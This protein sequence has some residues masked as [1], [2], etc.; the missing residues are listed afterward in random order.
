MQVREND[1]SLIGFVNRED[2]RIFEQLTSVTGVGAK[3]A[4]SIQSTLSASE[5]VFAVLTDDDK[6]LCRAPGI[7]KKIAQRLALELK[8]KFGAVGGSTGSV[9]LRPSVSAAEQS[10]KAEA[11]EA[12]VALSFPRVE[13]MRAVA[14][15]A[16]DGMS[17]EGIIKAALRKLG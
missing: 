15:T 3:A 5:I 17:A 10:P 13:A 1:V 11:V 6:A 7:G 14:E 16:V 4:L 2:M 9:D 8:G 12:L